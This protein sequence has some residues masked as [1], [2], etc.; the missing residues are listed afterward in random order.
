MGRLFPPLTEAVLDGAPAA[1]AK[2]AFADN[3]YMYGPPNGPM[4]EE[5][6]QR[7]QGPK[8]RTRVEMAV[9]ILRAHADGKCAARSAALPTTTDHG[10]PA[11]PWRQHHEAGAARQRARW[12]C[13]WTTAH[14]RLPRPHW[15]SPGDAGWTRRGDGEVW[16]LPAAEPLT[17]RQFLTLDYKAAGHPPKP[18]VAS[19][20]DDQTVGLF[21]PLV[22]E[23]NETLYQFEQPFTSD[24]SKFQAAFGPFEP[25]PH[26][27][28][29][30]PTVEWFRSRYAA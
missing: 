4:T 22:R 2:L 11:R 8:G 23:L 1:G 24:S 26:R 5:T 10:A 21:N 17:G 13:P 16:H 18:G 15:S 20:H 27:E 28:A 29:A 19:A 3:L 30:R 25:T 9:V 7:A 14:P 6:P 12:L